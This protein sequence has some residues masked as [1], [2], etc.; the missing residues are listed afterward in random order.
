VNWAD[1]GS[2]R[3]G[4][5]GGSLEELYAKER[6]SINFKLVCVKSSI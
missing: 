1:E 6:R 4:G 2:Q 5:A 3:A